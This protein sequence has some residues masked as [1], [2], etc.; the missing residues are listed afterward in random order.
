MSLCARFS[1]SYQEGPFWWEAYDPRGYPRSDLPKET[2]VAI[3][4]AGYTGLSAAIE[5]A[6]QGIDCC[7]IDRGDP[8]Y[9]ASTRSGGIVSG[10]GGIKL[11]LINATPDANRQAALIKAAADALTLLESRIIESGVDCQWRPNGQL[12]LANFNGQLKAMGKRRELLLRN[13]L[14]S[15]VLYSR[16]EL[17]ER[18][19]SRFYDGGMET[20]PGG[21]LHPALYFKALLRLVENSTT[22]SIAAHTDVVHVRQVKGGWHI[23]TSRGTIEAEHL[24]VATNG[25]TGEATPSL[26]KHLL[27]IKAYII[28]TEILDESLALEISPADLAFVDSTRIA[29]FYRLSGQAGSR[30]MIFGSRVKWTDI[31]ATEMAPHLYRQMLQRFPQL[32]GIGISHA[33]EGNVALTLDEQ[34]HEGALEGMHYA[35]GCNG[36]GVANMSWLGAQAA[37]R[38]VGAADYT[39]PFGEAFPDHWY[40]NGRQR[41]F[42]P[43]IGNYL[44]LR[45]WLDRRLDRL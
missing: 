40:Y 32:E 3:V 20:S 27:P 14:P 21:H 44:R 12:K 2:H 30:R 22:T 28:A 6:R 10:P 18:I 45:D 16:D 23:D 34:Y 17:G 36:S 25:Y 31:S 15:A 24:L 41:W 8:G 7:V 11:P 26:R 37:R 39:S 1:D 13:G 5:L 4:G 42:V 43:L 38:L 19:G 29:P 9:C 33:W 35:L